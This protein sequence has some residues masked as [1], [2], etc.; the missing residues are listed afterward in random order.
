MRII[1]LVVAILLST[2][3]ANAAEFGGVEEISGYLAPQY[4][5]WEEFSR[6]ERL[7]REQGWLMGAGVMARVNLLQGDSSSLILTGKAELFGG[8][9]DYDGQTQSVDQNGQPVQPLPVTTDVT[10]FGTRADVDAGWRVSGEKISLEPFLGIGS[11]IWLRDLQDSTTM[12]TN[13]VPVGV[14]GY[15]ENWRSYYLRF[16]GRFDYMF[17]SDWRLSCEG[18]AKFPF[19]TEN[20][21]EI[22]GDDIS[23]EPDGRWSS[24]AEVGL[25]RQ[26]LKISTFYEGFR[27]GQSPGV[28]SGF[29]TFIQPASKSDMYGV[30]LGWAF[31]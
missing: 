12:D 7:L 31:K 30:R 15:T 14:S 3:M 23:I 20:Q 5:A 2:S 11:R 18:G 24:F 13:G 10:Y 9:V 28:I 16:G 17:N 29:S 27:Y 1:K 21:V 22:A 26:Q 6:G 25:R 4:F 8:V 19:Y